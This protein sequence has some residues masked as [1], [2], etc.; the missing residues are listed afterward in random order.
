MIKTVVVIGGGPRDSWPDMSIFDNETTAY[1]GVDRGTLY[2]INAG[3]KLEVSVGDF[4]SLTE[5]EFQD[6]I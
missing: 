2:G 1:I 6:L 4:D 5:S 3:Y